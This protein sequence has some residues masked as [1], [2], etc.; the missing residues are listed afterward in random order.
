[1]YCGTEVRGWP[2]IIDGKLIT[3]R[4]TRTD[5]PDRKAEIRL[6]VFKTGELENMLRARGFE[7]IF[8]YML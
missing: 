6:H 3:F 1:M 4:Y 7:E 5:N 2:H 8:Q